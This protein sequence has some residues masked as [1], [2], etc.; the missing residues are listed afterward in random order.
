MATPRPPGGRR[1][2]RPLTGGRII[3]EVVQQA[4]IGLPQKH[5]T[6]TWYQGAQDDRN[7]PAGRRQ[8]AWHRLSLAAQRAH[9]GGDRLPGPNPPL[10]RRRGAAGDARALGTRRATTRPGSAAR[11][12]GAG[13]RWD[14]RLWLSAD[15]HRRGWPDSDGAEPGRRQPRGAARRPGGTGDALDCDVR[16]RGAEAAL[17]AAD[18]ADGGTGR[19]RADRARPW[20]GLGFAGD[21]GAPR[22]G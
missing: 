1:R 9:Q 21:D 15:E 17:A 16:Q 11:G 13:R 20:F 22:G 14:R 7:P 6:A 12:A 3:L 4:R 8:G 19:V 10:R 2:S 5:A 18:G